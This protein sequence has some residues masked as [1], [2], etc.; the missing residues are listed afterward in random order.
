MELTYFYRLVPNYKNLI[1]RA[2]YIIVFLFVSQILFCQE[3]INVEYLGVHQPKWSY[4]SHDSNF[5]KHP[6]DEVSTA[7]S[8]RY[9]VDIERI[10]D[11]IIILEQTLSPS[12]FLG[13]DGC[14][15][16]NIDKNSGDANWVYVDNY[17]TGKRN[18]EYFIGSK[19]KVNQ[20]LGELSFSSIRDNSIMSEIF[21]GFVFTGRP[22]SRVISLTNGQEVSKTYNDDLTDT[23][24][25]NALNLNIQKSSTKYFSQTDRLY[26]DS[27]IKMIVR[28]FEYEEGCDNYYTNMDSII[29]DTGI[30]EDFTPL[31]SFPSI[32]NR[33][34]DKL[35]YLFFVN[36]PYEDSI[37][38]EEMYLKE[39]IYQNE[40][41]EEL[42]SID[43]SD[44][45][46]FP[47]FLDDQPNVRSFQGHTLITQ[48]K[49]HPNWEEYYMFAW[50]DKEYNKLAHIKDLEYNGVTYFNVYPISL[51]DN[52]LRF[53]SQSYKGNLIDLTLFNLDKTSGILDSLTSINIDT[54]G[55]NFWGLFD[56]KVIG[57][58]E[59]LF[60][61]RFSYENS[62]GKTR[63]YMQYSL[64]ELQGYGITSV[65]E[66]IEDRNSFVKI[67]PNPA[68]E[69]L[70]V[71]LEEGFNVNR[72]RIYNY[73][74]NT[75]ISESKLVQNEINISALESGY[76]IIELVNKQG[77]KRFGRFMKIE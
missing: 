2:S 9:T 59:V 50:Y 12:N 57:T 4:L 18:R 62:T 71:E 46:S 76:Y 23:V 52:G 68:S 42:V 1:M 11:E 15:V 37:N 72:M 74:G 17:Y 35:R 61:S 34:G 40:K 3:F 33:D 45:T 5:V 75:V 24:F 41:V 22:S 60:K 43:M 21:P 58:D 25:L 70:N 51:D 53:F 49:R 47:N 69:I 14:M 63:N 30:N 16:H 56:F 54:K 66:E 6:L 27:S 65:N 67:Y 48:L 10:E 36:N 8:G 32:D 19:L 28:F 13:Q 31:A 64:F 77:E 29:F 44:L 20:E 26:Q 55:D 73:L 39:L 38:I 7:Y